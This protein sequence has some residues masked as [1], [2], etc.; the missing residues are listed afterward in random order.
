[1]PLDSS[2]PPN[3]QPSFHAA[4]EGLATSAHRR[5]AVQCSGIQG[6]GLFSRE[7]IAAGELVI[8]YCG[9]M[10]RQAVADLREAHYEGRGLGFYL[11]AVAGTH[12]VIDATMK[13]RLVYVD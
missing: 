3:A 6:W 1:V 2:L 12:M 7:A 13:V 8:E 11:F 4:F 9:E 5:T 10:V